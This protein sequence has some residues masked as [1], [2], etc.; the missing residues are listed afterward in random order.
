L[1]RTGGDRNTRRVLL[2]KPDEKGQLKIPKHRWKDNISTLR[3]LRHAS[4][5]EVNGTAFTLQD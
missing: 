1:A 2:K 5:F 3:S 4:Y